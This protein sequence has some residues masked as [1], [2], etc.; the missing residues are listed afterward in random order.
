MQ[1]HDVVNKPCHHV[2][3]SIPAPDINYDLYFPGKVTNSSNSNGVDI[4]AFHAASNCRKK[5][6]IL[7][8]FMT[9]FAFT[10][11]NRLK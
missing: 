4:N 9:L 10:M 5:Y 6:D 2:I 8:R 1:S 11:R 7:K 3:L